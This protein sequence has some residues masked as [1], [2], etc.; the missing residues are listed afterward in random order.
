MI[1]VAWSPPK[2][3]TDRR[4]IR[5]VTSHA[6][7]PQALWSPEQIARLVELAGVPVAVHAQGV[8]VTAVQRSELRAAILLAR[9][10]VS[11]EKQEKKP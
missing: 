10:K 2:V 5:Y 1:N 4:F 8:W 7:E 9:A 11:Q 6:R 3:W